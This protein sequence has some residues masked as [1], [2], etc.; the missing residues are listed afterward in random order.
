MTVYIQ[1]LY[2]KSDQ[3]STIIMWKEF[4]N[5]LFLP[6]TLLEYGALWQRLQ[7]VILLSVWFTV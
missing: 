4:L 6:V 7:I 3:E 5:V 1:H 2:G